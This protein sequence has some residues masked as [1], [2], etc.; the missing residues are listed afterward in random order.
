MTKATP[1][2]ANKIYNKIYKIINQDGENYFSGIRFIDLV[3]E[4]DSSFPD[5]KSYIEQRRT[6]EQSTTRRDFF[7][8]IFLS[9]TN[10]QQLEFTR[11]I[12]GETRQNNPDEANELSLLIGDPPIKSTESKAAEAGKHFTQMGDLLSAIETTSEPA[13]SVSD[14]IEEI[15]FIGHG[16]SKVWQDLKDFLQDRLNLDWDEFNR[17]PVAGYSTKERLEQMLERVTFAFLIMTAEDEHADETLHAREN[18]IHEIGLFQGRL[19]V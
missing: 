11:K 14:I 7:R 2:N 13:Q 6:T 19:G 16:R 18:V 5:Y 9:F 10:E 12:I 3:K 8:E 4:I 15:I 1:E 17:E